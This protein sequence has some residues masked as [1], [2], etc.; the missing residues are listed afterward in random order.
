ME[1]AEERSST[2]MSNG[3]YVGAMK[4]TALVCPGLTASSKSYLRNGNTWRS[5]KIQINNVF[6][7]YW[8]GETKIYR[9]IH[10]YSESLPF[11]HRTQPSHVL[12][13]VYEIQGRRSA[14][15]MFL[16][17]C[18]FQRRFSVP[19]ILLPWRKKKQNKKLGFNLGTRCRGIPEQSM[20]GA[21]VQNATAGPDDVGEGENHSMNPALYPVQHCRE[22]REISVF[23]LQQPSIACMP[24]PTTL[25][26][27]CSCYRMVRWLS[28]ETEGCPDQ[29]AITDSVRN[30]LYFLQILYIVR[31]LVSIWNKKKTTT[32]HY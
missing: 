22:Q 20:W 19:L 7:P 4:R 16:F 29:R 26:H 14:W 21:C 32:F 30:V 23:P 17:I 31:H 25:I 2:D 9:F 8:G 27:D 6:M 10:S 12:L 15:T 18:R 28:G 24:S 13:K 11:S 5:G 3:R 1:T